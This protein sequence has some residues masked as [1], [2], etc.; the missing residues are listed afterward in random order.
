MKIKDEIISL[1]EE[2]RKRRKVEDSMLPLKKKYPST[3]RESPWC[4]SGMFHLDLEDGWNV[5]N[6]EKHLKIVS[7]INFK[8]ESLQ[9]KIED[10]DKWRN[11]EKS[12]PS[13][14][15]SVKSYD[16]RL[17]TLA[18][19]ECQELASKFEKKARKILAGMMEVYEK[20]I[21][22]VQRYLH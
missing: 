20:S 21:Y 18:S 16:I 14:L 7:Q 11:M 15:P 5:K 9:T 13:I 6:L 10:L 4:K 8:M 3:T 12:V 22:Y 17:H 1:Q 2:M 19:N